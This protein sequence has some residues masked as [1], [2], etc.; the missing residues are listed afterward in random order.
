MDAGVPVSVR[1]EDFAIRRFHGIGRMIEG[2]AEPGLV[3]LAEDPL[4]ATVLGQNEDAVAVEVGQEEP[5]AGASAN[6]VSGDDSRNGP[7]VDERTIG[8]R[9]DRT[10][11]IRPQEHRHLARGHHRHVGDAGIR[12]PRRQLPPGPLNA[13]APGTQHNELL[14]G[15]SW[16]L[17]LAT[18]IA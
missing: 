7:L 13:I 16:V 4:A 3:A 6:V 18:A 5:A 14:C 10:G 2:L 12:K 11:G 1:H 8:R 17:R 9:G 15:T